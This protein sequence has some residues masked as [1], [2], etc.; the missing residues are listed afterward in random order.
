M[1]IKI[2]KKLIANFTFANQITKDTKKVIEIHNI[3]ARQPRYQWLNKR[4]YNKLNIKYGCFIPPQTHIGRGIIFPH[5]LFG[6]FISQNAVIGNNCVIFQ[7]VTIGSNTL[8]NSNRIGAPIIGNNVYIGAGAKIIGK[9]KIGNNVRIGAN[10]VVTKDVPDNATVVGQS[11][12]LI[13]HEHSL[14]NTFQVI[15]NNYQSK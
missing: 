4:K 9:C 13:E 15:Q 10:A 11:I 5:G 2:L 3:L 12:R 1:L 14:D 8:K 7:H 6:I